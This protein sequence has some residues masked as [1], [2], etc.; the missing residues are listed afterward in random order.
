[1]S[2]EQGTYTLPPTVAAARQMMIDLGRR[3]AV[4][5][6]AAETCDI[7]LTTNEGVTAMISSVGPT[8]FGSWIG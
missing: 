1:M 7:G 6:T 4:R 8:R 3:V 2:E 5:R